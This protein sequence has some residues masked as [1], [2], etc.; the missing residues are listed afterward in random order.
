VGV[1]SLPAGSPTCRDLGR[2][3][4]MAGQW[5]QRCPDITSGEDANLESGRWYAALCVVVAGQNRPAT[6]VTAKVSA[7]RVTGK[8]EEA[9]VWWRLISCR[10]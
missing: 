2:L 9:S 3:G 1:E 10:T 4:F 6:E 7:D 5:N 8:G